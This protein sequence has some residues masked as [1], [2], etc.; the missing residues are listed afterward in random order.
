MHRYALT[1]HKSQGAE[2]N[3]VCFIAE[4]SGIANWNMLYTAITRTKSHLRIV[5]LEG[6]PNNYQKRVSGNA[7]F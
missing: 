6:I 4:D 5:S 2:F 1:V 3:R 7:L